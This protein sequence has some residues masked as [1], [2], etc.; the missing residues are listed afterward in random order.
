[1]FI[2]DINILN[3]YGKLELDKILEEM[4]IGW[5]EL[6]V[7]CVLERE[8]GISQSNLTPFL[9]TDKANVTKIL[10]SMEKRK[11]IRREAL[12]QDLR[13]KICFLT[14]AGKALAPKLNR[15]MKEW[16]AVCF[17]GVS[18]ADRQQYQAVNKKITD[19]LLPGIAEIVK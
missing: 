11:L 16:E 6:I 13:N 1:M 5:H 4:K 17:R 7:I 3:R 19:N 15:V 12:E 10:Q 8:P 14:E 18:E 9:Q 2:C